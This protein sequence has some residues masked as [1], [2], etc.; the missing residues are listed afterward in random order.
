MTDEYVSPCRQGLWLENL[1]PHDSAGTALGLW[2]VRLGWWGWVTVSLEGAGA[3]CPWGPVQE[4]MWFLCGFSGGCLAL[5]FGLANL[6]VDVTS[7][8]ISYGSFLNS[9]TL[10]L[11]KLKQSEHIIF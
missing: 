9:P 2:G 8:S 1:G 4:K 5:N 6:F 3:L 11:G 10:F 7:V